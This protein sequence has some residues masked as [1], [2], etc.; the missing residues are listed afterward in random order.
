MKKD[1]V[2]K[3]KKL[4]E[5]Q[6]RKLELELLQTKVQIEAQQKQLTEKTLR[7]KKVQVAKVSCLTFSL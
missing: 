3:Q 7:A 1:L 6:Q 2:D 5:L 4:L